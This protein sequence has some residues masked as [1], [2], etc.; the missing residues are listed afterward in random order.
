ML[1]HIAIALAVPFLATI[2]APEAQAGGMLAQ[3]CKWSP[4]PCSEL[5]KSNRA[6][7]VNHR[8]QAMAMRNQ[9]MEQRSQ[10]RKS[11]QNQT[12]SQPTVESSAIWNTN[13][14]GPGGA[15]IPPRGIGA[16]KSREGFS[17]R[18]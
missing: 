1:K 10:A 9:E 11:N 15:Y 13:C 16:P 14:G 7:L 3:F 17:R 12:T 2:A 8:S 5:G 4:I 6:T 18:L